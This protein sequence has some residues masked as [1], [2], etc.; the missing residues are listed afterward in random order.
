[1]ELL[2]LIIEDLC[3]QIRQKS[4]HLRIFDNLSGQGE[5]SFKDYFHSCISMMLLLKSLED[6]ILKLPEIHIYFFK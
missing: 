5:M 6:N 3:E 4:D 1:M 2:Y